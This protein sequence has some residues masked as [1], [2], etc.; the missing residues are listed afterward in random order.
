MQTKLRVIR[1]L[2]VVSLLWT[3]PMSAAKSIAKLHK[4]LA[5][6][7][8]RYIGVAS[9]YGADRQGRKMANGRKFDRHMLTAACWYFPLGTVVRVV[10][11]RNGNAV[12]VTITDRGPNLRLH[13]ILD[14][15]Q[16]AAQQLDY[17][18]P[19]LTPVFVSPMP[20]ASPEHAEL[21]AHLAEPASEA[22]LSAKAGPV[23]DMPD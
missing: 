17:I 1:F 23:P 2:F 16:A 3:S 7:K 21:D 10:N 22:P 4:R 13:R 12:S 20:V 11:L 19:G 5:A 6:P 9:W 8:P 18:G 15:S 14:L